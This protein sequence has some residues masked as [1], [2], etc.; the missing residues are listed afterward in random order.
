MID[1]E[2]LDLTC[3]IM[4]CTIEKFGE[5]VFFEP[6]QHYFQ[7]ESMEMTCVSMLN[8]GRIE[9][10]DACPLCITDKKEEGQ[11]LQS[12][13]TKQ[14]LHKII[15]NDQ[16]DRYNRQLLRTLTIEREQELMQ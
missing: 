12:R 7:F 11:V 5:I 13:L 1:V 8:E 6:C 4:A 14:M 9:M 3:P 16:M 2:F 15:G 10:A